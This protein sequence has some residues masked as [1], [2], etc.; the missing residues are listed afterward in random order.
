MPPFTAPPDNFA[1]DDIID[2]QMTLGAVAYSSD[3]APP[4]DLV[5]TPMGPMSMVY[6][7]VLTIFEE[8]IRWDTRPRTGNTLI[9]TSP[10]K[11]QV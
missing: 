11:P 3:P 4:H 1:L 7:V 2:N 6:I 9:Q 5:L 10:L 8:D